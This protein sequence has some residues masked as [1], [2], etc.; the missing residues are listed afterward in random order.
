MVIQQKTGRPA[1]FEITADTRISLLAW[2]ERRGGTIDDFAFPSR[3]AANGLALTRCAERRHHSSTRPQATCERSR[4]CWFIARSRTPFDI[5]EWTLTTLSLVV[6]GDRNLTSGTSPASIPG[7][8]EAPHFGR[9]DGRDIM[10]QSCHSH[11]TD[12]A[13]DQH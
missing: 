11:L 9:S 7:V 6:R 5:W 10:P 8:G 13:Q 4:Y 12:L 2:L 1:Q 3:V